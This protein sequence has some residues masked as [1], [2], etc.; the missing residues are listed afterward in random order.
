MKDQAVA[1][2]SA[3]NLSKQ[4]GNRFIF[5][6]ISFQFQIGQ[7]VA[8][9]GRNGSGKS[10]LLQILAGHKSP[11]AGE[12]N[13]VLDGKKIESSQRPLSIGFASPALGLPEEIKLD[14]FLS[15][16]F[17]I[18]NSILSPSAIAERIGLTRAKNLR[19]RELSSG[20]LQR[21]R[22]AIAMFDVA[23]VLMLDEPCQNLD[24]AGIALYHDLFEEVRHTKLILVAGND[25]QEYGLCREALEVTD[26]KS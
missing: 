19:L 10:T 20:M 17:S 21:V 25:P 2:L 9:T 4:Y 22:L 15:I 26:F 18:R 5:R 8:I 3:K 12:V 1:T 23:P 11:S 13:L 16:H 24:L 6:G 14:D 7:S